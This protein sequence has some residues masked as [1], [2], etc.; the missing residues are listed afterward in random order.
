MHTLAHTRR[1]LSAREAAEQLGVGVATVRRAAHDG[2]LDAVRVRENGWL[3]F[4]VADVEALV[5]GT[6]ALPPHEQAV[7]DGLRDELDAHEV[8]P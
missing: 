7:L 6:P 8:R 5:A 3:R 2:R 1:L 4:R